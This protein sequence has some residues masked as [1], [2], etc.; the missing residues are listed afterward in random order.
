MTAYGCQLS[1]GA[2]SNCKRDA[3]HTYTL[4]G[5]LFFSSELAD[6]TL[7]FDDRAN[8][9]AL[10]VDRVTLIRD[11]CVFM[12][13]GQVDLAIQ[14]KNYVRVHGGIH[15]GLFNRI[16]SAEYLDC[17]A[18]AVIEG[19][20]HT[21]RVDIEGDDDADKADPSNRVVEEEVKILP[22]T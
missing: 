2:K 10:E 18:T 20:N 19:H 16:L 7:D 14:L 11:A 3:G 22:Y 8:I 12:V 5:Y 6:P 4:Q 9:D 15:D 21:I 13:N 1:Q 17:G